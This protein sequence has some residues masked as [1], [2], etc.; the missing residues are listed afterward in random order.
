MQENNVIYEISQKIQDKKIV[1]NDMKEAIDL[2]ANLFK[3]KY[4]DK[5]DCELKTNIKDVQNNPPKEI[6][7]LNALK[8]FAEKEKHQNI[9]NI[10]NLATNIAAFKNLIPKQQPK[11]QQN[12]V[13]ASNL[14]VDPS[15]K[16]DGV[17]DI[18]ENCLYYVN[19]NT[20][21]QSGIMLFIFLLL[22][23]MPKLDNFM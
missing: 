19:N 4:I 18:D 12:V 10:I 6:V 5:I 16:E 14:D 8:P 23:L 20:N 3:T 2:V 15:V 21:N 13:K 22:F 9:D 7:L 1:Q 17:Y 11:T